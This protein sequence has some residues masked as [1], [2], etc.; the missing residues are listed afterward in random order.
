MPSRESPTL[1]LTFF[2][3]MKKFF[4]LAALSA[5]MLGCNPKV[6]GQTP[7]VTEARKA[8]IL[9]NLTH[10]LPQLARLDP[11]IVSLEPSDLPGLD[12]G[13]FTYL[14]QRGRQAQE[15]LVTVDDKQLYL[16]AAG[17][18]DVSMSVEEIA[19]A[20]AA[21]R[22]KTRAKLTDAAKNFPV[23]GNPDAPITIVEFSD[24]QCPYC[25]RASTTVEQVLAKYPEDV[26]IAYAHFPLDFHPWARPAAIGAV[27]AAKQDVSA[28]WKLHDFFF[29]NQNQVNEEN[30]LDKTRDIL[31]GTKVDLDAWSTCAEDASSPE[32]VAAAQKVD[33][34]A[35]LGV[36]LGVTGTPA[37][38]I[39]GE[40]LNGA[41]PLQAFEQIIER[42]KQQNP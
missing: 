17:P 22:E 14:T 33:T 42:V 31:A 6:N 40:F 38:F 1:T 41:Q 23:R 18:L 9:A 11:Q 3:Y 37:F 20:E 34:E 5:L 30:V 24:F 27:C 35:S 25:A 4:A 21:E 32:Y 36:E 15:F 7:D 39:N 2:E 29:K 26:R 8:K 16:I 10:Q 28:F 13:S 12:R 19:S